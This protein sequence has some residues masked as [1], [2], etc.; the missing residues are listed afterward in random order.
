M[1]I[2]SRIFGGSSAPDRAEPD[3]IRAITS[4]LD[5]MPRERARF[6]AAYA[7]V[8]GRV[9][10]ADLEIDG[11]EKRAMERS[12]AEQSELSAA[13]VALVVEIAA[14]QADEAGGADNYL[15][16]REFRRTSEREDR[17]R[18]MRCL[19]AVAA[20]DDSIS[21]TESNEIQQIGEEL[22]FTRSEITGLRLEWRDK[23]AVLKPHANREPEE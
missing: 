17:I 20:A 13:E 14:N 4:K 3:S 5:R 1:S 9:A 16:V 6:L 21:T 22:G 12:I 10:N 18:L 19:F 7:Y 11:A 23:I 15:V 2:F 8:L